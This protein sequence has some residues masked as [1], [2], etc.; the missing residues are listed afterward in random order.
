MRG[1]GFAGGYM[2]GLPIFGYHYIMGGKFDYND[3]LAIISILGA[4]SLLIFKHFYLALSTLSNFLAILKRIGEVLD[5]EE[6]NINEDSTVEVKAVDEFK[7]RTED[8]E[9]NL[10][11]PQLIAVTGIVGSGKSTLL[12]LLI[13]KILN[14]NKQASIINWFYR[15]NQ[16]QQ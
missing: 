11:N 7:Y 2:I 10:E 15:L 6:F 16:T 13:S 9:F 1:I 12:S 3:S 14:K 5:M 4:S 8:F